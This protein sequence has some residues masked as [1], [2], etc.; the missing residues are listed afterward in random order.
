MTSQVRPD[1]HAVR[2]LTAADLPAYRA[3][4]LHA[5]QA[6]ADA[7]TTTAEERAAEPDAWWLRRIADPKGLGLA[8]GA[9]DGDALHGTVAVEFSAKPKTRH[10]ALVVGMFVHASARGR[11]LG[12][13]L[14]QAALQVARERPGVSVVAL[15]VTEGNAAALALYASCGFRSWGTEPMAILTPGGYRGKVHLWRALEGAP[16]A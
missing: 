5:Y 12:R 8:L 4:M 2:P 15:T 6:A 7:F 11:G 13:A 14:M 10:R 3:L 16:A 9:F 1:P